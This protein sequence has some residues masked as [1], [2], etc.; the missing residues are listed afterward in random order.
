MRLALLSDSFISDSLNDA[1]PLASMPRLSRRPD[2]FA[3]LCRGLVALA[4][5]LLPM[6]LTLAGIAPPVGIEDDRSP[7]GQFPSA[8]HSQAPMSG[9]SSHTGRF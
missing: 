5:L 8:W 3:A 6:G 9:A 1:G 2:H 7:I 4:T